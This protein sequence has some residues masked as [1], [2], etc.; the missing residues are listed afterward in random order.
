MSS[1]F[2]PFWQQVYVLANRFAIKCAP[3]YIKK[4][5]HDFLYQWEKKQAAGAWPT[6]KLW[7]PHVYKKDKYFKN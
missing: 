2:A 3:I 4:I 5:K 7:S 6:Q 1:K